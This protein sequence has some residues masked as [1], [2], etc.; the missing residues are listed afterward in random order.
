[1]FPVRITARH[2]KITDEFKEYARQKM[3]KLDK[4]LDR[5]KHVEII[6]DHTRNQF[7]AEIIISVV[8]G[9]KLV[10]KSSDL[11]YFTALDITVDKMEKQLTKFKELLKKS[12]TKYLY[13]ADIAGTPE[14]EDGRYAGL[15]QDDWY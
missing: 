15:D 12:K 4:Y 2:T 1:M 10:G 9:K 14:P 3:E 11:N 6:L 13:L 8:R 7:E 5:I